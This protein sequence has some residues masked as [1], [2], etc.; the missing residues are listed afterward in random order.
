[1]HESTRCSE[2][3]MEAAGMTV[4]VDAVG[5]LRGVW[6]GLHRELPA[7]S[8]RFPSRHRPKRRSLRRRPWRRP[9]RRRR[10][11]VAR[12][13]IFPSPSKSSA[14]PKKKGVRFSKPFLGSLA[15]IGKLDADILARTDRDGIRSP[16]RFATS[17]STCRTLPDAVRR[18]TPSPISSSTSSRGRA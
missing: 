1:M 17:A 8:H 9:R 6:P 4:R 2:D 10:R 15:V 18:T 13:S 16:K 14:S 11:E 5:N 12:R 3:W 7:S